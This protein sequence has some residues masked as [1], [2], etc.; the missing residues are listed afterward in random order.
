MISPSKNIIKMLPD[1]F[2]KSGYEMKDILKT[3]DMP[4]I[5]TNYG[6]MEFEIKD[7]VA[8][9][10]SAYTKNNN[11]QSIWDTFMNEI[12]KQG[13]IKVE[14]ITYRNPKVWEKLYKFKIKESR[15]TLDLKGAN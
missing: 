1:F 15:L 10:Y 13:C 2:K 11:T 12:K 3:G 7:D 5:E 9:V 14:M 8:F 4:L 6:W